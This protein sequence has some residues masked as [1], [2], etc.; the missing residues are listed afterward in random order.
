MISVVEV[1]EKLLDTSVYLD[2]SLEKA[3]ILLDSLG[4]EEEGFQ[5]LVQEIERQEA[6]RR[7]DH[8]VLLFF[9]W[10][11]LFGMKLNLFVMSTSMSS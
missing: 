6:R 3:L 2:D 7:F 9:S 11:L 1:D 5:S 4:T 10:F 8:Q